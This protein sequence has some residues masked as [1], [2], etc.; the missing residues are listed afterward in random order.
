MFVTHTRRAAQGSILFYLLFFCITLQSQAQERPLHSSIANGNW[1]NEEVWEGGSLPGNG[2]YVLSRDV[3]VRHR[4]VKGER[5]VLERSTLTLFE[6]G[7][8]DVVHLEM[9]DNNIIIHPGGILKAFK[10]TFDGSG[11]SSPE[12]MIVRRIIDDF[13]YYFVDGYGPERPVFET[14][15]NGAWADPSIWEGNESPGIGLLQ[16]PMEIRIKHAVNAPAL[17]LDG[18]IEINIEDGG[19]LKG[20]AIDVVRD[21]YEGSDAKVVLHDGGSLHLK[22]FYYNTFEGALHNI[23]FDAQDNPLCV[24]VD[25]NEGYHAFAPGECQRLTYSVHHSLQDGEWSNPE[26]WDVFAGLET[27]RF[28]GADVYIDHKVFDAENMRVNGMTVIVSGEYTYANTI[29]NLNSGKVIVSMGGLFK[30]YATEEMEEQ[31]PEMED[32]EGYPLNKDSDGQFDLFFAGAP[33]PITLSE[34]S[35]REGEAGHVL[36]FATASEENFDYFDIERSPDGE[37]FT[38]IGQVQGANLISGRRY[39]YIDRNPHP[40][41]NYYRLKQVDRDGSYEYSRVVHI[42]NPLSYIF[43]GDEICFSEQDTYRVRI[44]STTGQLLQDEKLSRGCLRLSQRPGLY[45]VEISNG[46]M[47]RS[48]KWV[49]L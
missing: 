32:E 33:M 35:V 39:R 6:E 1:N 25:A 10:T 48:E 41:L 28:E 40:G 36:D 29:V 47:Q 24:D 38:S 26:T 42:R 12:G 2:N 23:Y 9:R 18:M 19:A 21:I 45:L 17:R 44:F 7:F 31:W 14:I 16:D 37:T 34:F 8:L 22:A 5:L 20:D 13:E 27:R 43:M 49:S 3:E 11:I 15:R 30:T 46:E 4:L